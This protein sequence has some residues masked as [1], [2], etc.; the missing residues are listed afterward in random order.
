MHLQVAVDAL[1]VAH[2]ALCKEPAFPGLLDST[3]DFEAK[4]AQAKVSCCEAQPL[5]SRLE[6]SQ[7]AVSKLQFDFNRAKG[8]EAACQQHLADASARCEEVGRALALNANVV[9]QL[10]EML[11]AER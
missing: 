2:V 7:V 1:Q 10:T 3:A 5:V 9:A 4:L 8:K 6:A 11:A